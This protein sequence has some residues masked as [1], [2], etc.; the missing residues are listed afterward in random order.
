MIRGGMGAF[1]H[2]DWIKDY[3]DGVLRKEEEEGRKEEERERR[4]VD[5]VVMLP[6]FFRRR[7]DGR[8]QRDREQ[9]VAAES[10]AMLGS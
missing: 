9:P 8:R 2:V 4:R 10:R 6:L 5:P 7:D 1:L 3:V